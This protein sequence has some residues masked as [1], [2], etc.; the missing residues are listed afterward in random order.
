MPAK[1]D[2]P[3]LPTH[4]TRLP[5]R[6]GINYWVRGFHLALPKTRPATRAM[7]CCCLLEVLQ[8]CCGLIESYL[9]QYLIAQD[10]ADLIVMSSLVFAAIDPVISDSKIVLQ[11]I[12]NK[13]THWNIM[14]T[15]EAKSKDPTDYDLE[16]GPS[17]NKIGAID[18]YYQEIRSLVL[19]LVTLFLSQGYLVIDCW[20]RR[21]L[22]VIVC[23]FYSFWDTTLVTKDIVQCHAT[24]HD[25]L[26]AKSRL[27]GRLLVKMH[28][29]SSKLSRH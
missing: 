10:K 19:N 28:K 9:V 18:T 8:G 17:I 24:T 15:L 3:L 4:S 2:D 21:N 20:S 6:Y 29:L 7:L 23:L 27:S 25:L 11:A 14:S 1:E 16:K 26:A 13:E 22:L 5:Y 12:I